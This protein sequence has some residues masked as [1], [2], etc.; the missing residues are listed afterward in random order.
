MAENE[1]NSL[2]IA[3]ARARDKAFGK[4]IKEVMADKKQKERL[5]LQRCDRQQLVQYQIG[6]LNRL[7][8][9]IL[10]ENQFYAQKLADVDL[11][12]FDL[13]DLQQFPLTTKDELVAAWTHGGATAV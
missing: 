12:I 1:R 9:T 2:S 7:L 6:R 3:E 13:S 11:P 8:E 4:M 10:P 5:R